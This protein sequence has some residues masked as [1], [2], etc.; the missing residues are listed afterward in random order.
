[1]KILNNLLLDNSSKE[2]IK[3]N[4]KYF[5]KNT[6]NKKKKIL[7]E[8]NGWPTFHLANSYLISAIKKDN[9]YDVIAYENYKIFS[10]IKN[11]WFQKI[12]W[13]IGSFLKLKTF[14][15]YESFG[16][17]KYIQPKINSKIREQSNKTVKKILKK[18]KTKQDVINLKVESIWIGDLI[19]DTYLKRYSVYTVSIHDQK[20]INFLYSFICILYFWLF[21]FKENKI[22]SVVT[23]H[24]VYISALLLRIASFQGINSYVANEHKIYKFNS[25]LKKQTIG[26]TGNFY[27]SRFF[28]K[29]FKESSKLKKK[30][31]ISSGKK[32]TDSFFKSNKYNYYTKSYNSKKI[33]KSLMS[34]N[35]VKVAILLHAFSD[36]PNVLGGNLFPDFFEWLKFLNDKIISNTNYEWYIKPHPNFDEDQIKLI[37]NFN[38][39]SKIKIIPKNYNLYHLDKLKISF[40]LT[41]FGSIN[42]EYPMKNIR[43]INACINNQY[44]GFKLS[45]T[46]INIK[47]YRDIL[48]KLEK[49]FYKIQ[50]SEIYIYNYMDNI[51]FDRKYLF[52]DFDNFTNKIGGKPKLYE[53]RLYSLWLKKFTKK[54]HKIIIDKIINFIKSNDY[55]ISV[56]H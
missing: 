6:I 45:L 32:I 52:N 47:N 55:T 10:Y 35:K 24:G 44:A 25:F 13:Y 30:Q 50:K 49:N 18:I 17:N 23:G 22:H 20:F 4:K 5:K 42:K 40:A 14:K 53:T 56:K 1:M 8:F 38:N 26:L 29:I 43:V 54:N 9:N 31:I 21:Y 28:K 2:F 41:M 33:K 36:S 51:Y 39:L 15:I 16:I 46:P 19:Y 11:P 3:H 48:L 27:E 34:Q 7:I 37:K 12:K